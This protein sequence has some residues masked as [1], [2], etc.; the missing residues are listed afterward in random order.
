LVHIELPARQ[1]RLFNRFLRL[2]LAADKQNP[3]A[4]SRDVLEKPRC[5]L[6]LPHGFIE[7][8]NVNLIA[9]F[10][11]E[12]LHLWI[13]ALRLVSKMNASFQKFRH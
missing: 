12:G 6:K 10:E 11:D 9:L 3:S 8:D 2:F 13:P 1:G 5:T 7:V 4:A